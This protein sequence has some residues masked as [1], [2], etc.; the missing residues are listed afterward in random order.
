MLRYSGMKYITA[1]TLFLIGSFTAMAQPADTTGKFRVV[2]FIVENGDTI[3]VMQTAE[4]EI[5][6]KDL[7]SRKL[8]YRVR[9]VYPYAVIVA[10]LLEK[11]ESDTQNMSD[12]Q[13]KL[14]YKEAH[15]VLKI[16]FTDELKNLSVQSGQVLMKLIHREAGMSAYD[17]VSLMRGGMTAKLWETAAKVYGSSMKQEYDPTGVDA[18]IEEL[19]LQ[20]ERGE[21]S[22]IERKP[23]TYFAKEAVK[24]RK[25]KKRERKK[26][27][28]EKERELKKA[29]KALKKAQKKGMST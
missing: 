8:E 17:L 1:I 25:R 26:A 6:E 9:L 3:P 20:I 16:E 22:Y 5:T 12:R 18:E 27:N 13:K 2:P 4:F 19:V 14:Y 10:S 11:F 7:Q 28:R 23:K 15:K 29:A 21:L 24:E